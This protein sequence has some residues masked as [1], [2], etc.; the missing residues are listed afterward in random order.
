M[1]SPVIDFSLSAKK[2]INY[3]TVNSK[4]DEVSSPAIDFTMR[5][6]ENPIYKPEPVTD[7]G[8]LGIT[9]FSVTTTSV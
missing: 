8:N 4:G 9:A 5:A 2:V 1:T 7:T 3:V 6:T